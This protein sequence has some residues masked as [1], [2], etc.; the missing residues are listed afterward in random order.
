MILGPETRCPN[1]G[2]SRPEN[3]RFYLPTDAEIVE[4]EARLREAKSGPD[5]ICGYCK[6]QNKAAETDCHG[7]GNTRDSNS[8]EVRLEER[9]YRSG[10][11]P[12]DSFAKERTIHPL[13]QQARKKPK[14]R[15][16]LRLVFFLFLAGLLGVF[17]L[18]SFPQEI[19]VT[20]E[21]FRWERQVQM[22]HE[23]PVQQEAWQVPQGA[24][25]VSSF[26]A[27]REYK[28]VLRGYETRTRDVRVKVGEERYV[29]GQIDKGNGYFVDKY[30]TRPIYETRQET[31]EQPV[32]DQVPIYATKYRFTIMAWVE[33]DLLK[34]AGTDQQAVWPN[35]P[36]KPDPK[37]WKE[38]AKQETYQI[39]VKEDDGDTHLETI[40]FS[41]WSQLK[42]G[43]TIKA[44]RSFLF[45]IYYGLK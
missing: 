39:T 4:D 21:A 42:P 25:D 19:D 10:A 37:R 6:T 44:K 3:I 30:C 20:V 31:Y 13:E 40:P 1:C 23:E 18:R 5:W 24:F 45:D 33:A 35:A 7:C 15:S 11:V 14:K 36:P 27:V 16:P 43:Q 32:Y 12:T 29:C 22:M 38:G 9:E 41:R 26:R 17:A 28:Q 34:S 2:A 8:E